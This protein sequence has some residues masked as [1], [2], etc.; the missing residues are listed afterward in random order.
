MDEKHL[1]TLRNNILMALRKAEAQ[2]KAGNEINLDL[3]ADH[4]RVFQHYLTAHMPAQ[5]SDSLKTLV[6][7]TFMD[8]QNLSDQIGHEIALNKQ[9]MAELAS[10]QKLMNTYTYGIRKP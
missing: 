7:D 8:I 2:L 4:V 5:P 1:Q 10:S 6:H 3:L 9:Y